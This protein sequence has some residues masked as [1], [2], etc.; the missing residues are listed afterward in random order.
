MDEKTLLEKVKDMFKDECDG[1]KCYSELAEVM[2]RMYPNKDY[3][4]NLRKIAI[5]EYRHK[6]YIMRLLDDMGAFVP[7][8]IKTAWDDAEEHYRLMRSGG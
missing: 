3:A 6:D 1:V 2:E 8:D 4:N 7:T 5:D